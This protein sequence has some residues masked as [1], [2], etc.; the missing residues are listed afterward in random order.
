MSKKREPIGAK[1]R[2]EVFKRDSFT[3]QYCGRRAP[4]VILHAD[5]IRPVAE[6]GT[7]D[8]LNLVTS[9]QPCNSGK[10]ARP[11]SDHQMIN[12]AVDQMAELE[13]R[14]QQIEMMM[15]WQNGLR[16]IESDNIEM[17]SDRMGSRTGYSPNA[18]GMADLRKWA[19]RFSAHELARAIDEAFDTYL[20][21]DGD[22]VNVPSWNKAFKKIP[23]VA[24]VLKQEEAKPYLRRIMYI[25]GIV[26]KRIG[27]PR[28][29]CLNY[30]EHLVLCGFDVDEL[31]RRA[32]RIDKFSDFDG[33]LDEWLASIGDPF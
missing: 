30:L 27:A 15:E 23:A 26:R 21:Y 13:E 17:L 28:F 33:P 7:T 5:H 20:L 19:K 31:E 6:G 14:R 2:F 24:A 8:I 10:G 22:E 18:S 3:C 29:D 25:Q 4:D 11:L 16:N 32:K 1:L 12:Q 9:C